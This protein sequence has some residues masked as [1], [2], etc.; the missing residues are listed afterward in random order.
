MLVQG[1]IVDV[2]YGRVIDWCVYVSKTLSAPG[3]SHEPGT[4]DH[5]EDAGLWA[6]IFPA[7]VFLCWSCLHWSEHVNWYS[8]SCTR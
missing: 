8:P 7:E 4:P 3:S 5:R 1:V 6:W 2:I